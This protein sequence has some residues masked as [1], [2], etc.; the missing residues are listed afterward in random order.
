M[1]NSTKALLIAGGV[2]IAI[3]MMSVLVMTLQKTGNVSRTYDGTIQQEEIT[4]FNTNFTQYIG[5][6]LTIHDVVTICNFAKQNGVSIN[7]PKVQSDIADV[8]KEEIDESTEEDT[9]KKYYTLT[10]TGS[11]YGTDGKINKISFSTGSLKK[12]IKNVE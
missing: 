9:Y 12:V 8:L 4:K 6:D 7:N 1:E 5:Q 3:L 10:I 2:L 11:D